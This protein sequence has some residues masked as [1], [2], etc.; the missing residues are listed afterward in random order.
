MSDRRVDHYDKD[1]G[2]VGYDIESDAPR[3]SECGGSEPA[4]PD[5]TPF[6]NADAIGMA[7]VVLGMGALVVVVLL[8]IL[9]LA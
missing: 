4:G 2:H 9:S 7:A 8:Y 6:S 3:E 1:G 5:P